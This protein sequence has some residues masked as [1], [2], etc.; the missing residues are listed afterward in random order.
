MSASSRARYDAIVNRT[1]TTLRRLLLAIAIPVLAFVALGSWAFSSPVASSPDDDFHLAS[2]W[3]GLGERDGLCENPG[4]D[5]F[6]RLIPTPLTTATCFAFRPEV[7]GSCWVSDQPGMTLVERANADGLYPKLFYG[8]MSIFAG[9]DIPASVIT[10]RL[11]NA[12]FAVGFLTVVFWAL[13][14]WMRPA[15]FVS[16][17][18]TSVPVGVFVLASTNPSSWAV[19]SGATVWISLY[20]ATQTAG[21][22]R[23]ALITI[24][25]FG[26]LIGA[27]ARADAAVYAVFGAV[28][29]MILGARLR[30]DHLLPIAAAVVITIISVALYLSAWQG[31][32]VVNGMVEGN[33]PLSGGQILS[34]AL[35]IPSLWTGALGG[36]A[37]GWIDTDLPAVVEVLAAAVFA[38]AL[39]VGL[40]RVSVRRTLAV[41]AGFLALWVVPFVLLYQ[42]RTVVGDLVQPRYLLPLMVIAI[43]VAS[44]RRDAI[45]SWSGARLWLAGGALTIA[46]A[47][48][49][50]TNIQRYTTGTDQMQLD[51]GANGEWWWN[52]AP[53]PLATWVI[54]SL[55]FAGIFVLI[56]LCLPRT[57]AE[58]S[59]SIALTQEGDADESPVMAPTR[60][61]AG[62]HHE[63]NSLG[64]AQPSTPRGGDT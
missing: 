19:L 8:T 20:A 30:K 45:A 6:E 38:G 51:P 2:T 43:G 41:A 12:A 33:P 4:G 9:E 31:S 64:V 35:E 10:M 1:G 44:L 21:R 62:A 56:S 14:R 42:S 23:L 54:G 13:P 28:I 52:A 11:F 3:C 60:I 34:N 63:T 36:W 25:I 27:G 49:L 61:E 50:R 7:S 15:L 16:V 24:A 26:T 48:S 32:A 29:A 57:A 17:A 39:F 40:R 53:S 18:V 46:F 37:L 22:R 55:A 58:P 5:T 47:V 59:T